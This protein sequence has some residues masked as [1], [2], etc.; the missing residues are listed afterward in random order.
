MLINLNFRA[1]NSLWI[2]NG[3]YFK[4]RTLEV[5]Y[6]FKKHQLK[7]LKYVNA[8]KVYVRAYDLFSLDHI[9]VMDPENMKTGHPSMT[10]YA[11]GFDLKF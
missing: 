8:A 5:Y 11:V 6:H 2:K 3:A 7:P 4:L 9:K 10:R 1:N